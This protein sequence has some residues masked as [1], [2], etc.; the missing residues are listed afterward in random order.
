MP[1]RQHHETNFQRKIFAEMVYIKKEGNKS[2]NK[3]TDIEI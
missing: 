3:I 2:I 1:L